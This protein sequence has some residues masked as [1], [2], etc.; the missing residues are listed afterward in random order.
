[1]RKAQ[2]PQDVRIVIEDKPR[3]RL[4]LLLPAEVKPYLGI[5]TAGMCQ[6]SIRVGGASRPLVIPFPSY[7]LARRS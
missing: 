4:L 1:M 3:Q 6:S 7:S 5:D 2:R